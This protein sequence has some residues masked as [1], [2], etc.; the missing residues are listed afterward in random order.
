MRKLITSAAAGIALIGLS[1]CDVEQTEEGEMP[2]VSVEGGNLPE[3][4]VDVPEVVVGTE[5]RT[6]DVPVIGVEPADASAEGDN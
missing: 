4:N 6:I 5:E 2:E 3:Y 1:A